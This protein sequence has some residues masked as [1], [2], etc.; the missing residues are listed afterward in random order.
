MA[1]PSHP[2]PSHGMCGAVRI[3][4]CIQMCTELP[5]TP[6]QMLGAAGS[7]FS[8]ITGY[9]SPPAPGVYC[10]QGSAP[11][12]RDPH[13]IPCLR[14]PTKQCSPLTPEQLGAEWSVHP[15]IPASQCPCIHVPVYWCIHTSMHLYVSKCPQIHMLLHPCVLASVHPC[16]HV[17][18]HPCI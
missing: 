10:P 5:H 12:P 11:A 8:H 13:L 18:I 2:I 14:F 1:A 17:S 4:V 9:T 16:A 3:Q 6:I 7:G 15:Y